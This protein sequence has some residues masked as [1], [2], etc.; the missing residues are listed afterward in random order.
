MTRRRIAL[1]GA[2]LLAGVPLA[3]SLTL[4]NTANAHGAMESPLSRVY[5]CFLEGPENPQTPAC[6]DAVAA[7][8]TQPLYDWM[9][10]NI[11]N[12]AGRH[13]EIIPDG[14]LC[15]ANRAKYAAFDAPRTDWHTTDMT[16]GP[17]TFRFRATAPH[18]GSFE[19]YLTRTGYDPIQPLAW[20][21]LEPTP[22]LRVVDP[23]LVDGSYEM[24]G[25]LPARTGRHLI[26]TIWQRSD[27]PEAFYT[28]SDITFDGDIEPTPT[29]SPTATATPTPTPT[30]TPS[31]TPGDPAPWQAFTSYAVGTLV[32]FDGEVYECRQAHDSLPGWEPPGVPALWLSR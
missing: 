18:R 4:V 2:S 29:P 1:I 17:Y 27:S 26:Y 11:A 30:P 19:L 5:A 22:F 15:S 3:L 13:R 28:C 9:E 32:T 8:G 23:P 12:A 24:T 21:A 6:Q 31:P 25:E 10:V 14:R 7:G 20:D 16:A